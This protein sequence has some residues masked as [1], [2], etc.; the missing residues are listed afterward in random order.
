MRN[1]V[2]TAFAFFAFFLGVAR[3]QSPIVCVAT[4]GNPPLRAE[5]IT[6]TLGDIFL[7]CTGG[8]PGTALT[9]NFLV[10]LNVAVS[11]RISAANATDVSLTVDSGSG[12]AATAV[13]GILQT[14]STVG[15]NG[16]TLTVPAS[17]AFNLHLSNLRGNVSQLGIG[18]QRP[19]LATL[20]LSSVPGTIVSNQSQLSVGIPAPG[21][22]ASLA[23]TGIRCTGSALPSATPYTFSSLYQN[24]TRFVSTRV[25]EGFP[26]SFQ[27]RQPKADTGVRFIARYSGFPA[28]A[29][30]FVPTVVAGSDATQPTAAGD[31]GGTPATG[32]Y[33]PGAGGSLLLSLVTGTDANGAGGV[34]AYTPGP[35]GSGQVNFNGV[36]QVPLSSGGG[37]AVYEVVDS[38][39]GQIE[40]AQ[41]PTFLGLP[42]VTNGVTP[43]A[44]EQVSLA[45][46]STVF[47]A[48][49]TDPIPRFIQSTPPSDCPQLADCNAN[50]FPSLSV[51]ALQPLQFTAPAGAFQ[52]T[53]TVQ[54]N[55]K[56][57]GVLSWTAS[58]GYLNGSNWLTVNPGAGV[59]G[60]TLMV[61]V[62]PA[63]VG[64]G[65]YNATL[66]I[67]AGPQAGSQTL[68]ITF[69]VTALPA[70]VPTPVPT[71]TPTPAPAPQPTVTVQSLTSAANPA[72]TAISPGSL[73][74]LT[75][76]NLQGKNVS[77]TFNGIPA[78]I[79]SAGSTR[80]EA[81]APPTLASNVAA[82][83]VV[84]ADAGQSAPLSIPI[85]ELAPAIFPAGILNQDGSVN[86]DSSPANTGSE[87]QIFATGLSASGPVLVK[88]HDRKPSPV[89]SGPAPGLLGVYQVNVDVP[90]DLPAMTTEVQL[91]GYGSANP[92]QPV[93]SASALLTIQQP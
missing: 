85:S 73:V 18:V 7:N 46:V 91:C 51:L 58:S 1:R 90:D 88:L 50:Y 25:T 3:P 80:I 40:T 72:S 10:S 21:L 84:T 13:P 38:N 5:G 57:G 66:F 75:G 44:S 64:P 93:C 48:S 56:G 54:I 60:G 55:N 45:P 29:Q 53:K 14:G 59:N 74:I 36:T 33:T 22:L 6:E 61:T 87:I 37:V 32:S 16:I 62:Y 34:L 86:G 52:L 12:A 4:A 76:M 15:F 28:G 23:T 67:D 43:V 11:N 49:T 41:F 24:G 63:N 8:A 27:P 78:T 31:L 30:L 81:Q 79:L 65:V 19:V 89:F 92:N 42:P 17:G 69:T 71:P 70:P 47:T 82:T 68:P 26:G 20:S 83:V 77:V 35:A 2:V 39:P 9:L